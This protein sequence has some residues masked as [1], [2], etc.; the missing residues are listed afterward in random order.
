MTYTNT[1]KSTWLDTSIQ[2]HTTNQ[3]SNQKSINLNSLAQYSKYLISSDFLTKILKIVVKLSYT[4]KTIMCN[5]N[6][7]YFRINQKALPPF[8]YWH[9]VNDFTYNK[10]RGLAGRK[11]LGVYQFAKHR[12]YTSMLGDYGIFVKKENEANISIGR[13]PENFGEVKLLRDTFFRVE[14]NTNHK[15]EN[16]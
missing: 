14:W 4:R 16:K 12:L 6:K 5:E 9:L 8:V 2:L 13:F 1:K 10:V 3:K 11:F 15:G 7:L